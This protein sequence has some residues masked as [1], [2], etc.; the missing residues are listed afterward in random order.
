MLAR[1]LVFSAAAL[2]LP[3]A[4]CSGSS[5]P[6]TDEPVDDPV[7]TPAGSDVNDV[8]FDVPPQDD[9][10][11]NF[12][13][14][15]LTVPAGDERQ[16]CVFMKSPS[17]DLY[18]Q[19]VE[20]LQGDGGHHAILLTTALDEPDGTVVDCTN[21][22]DM[23]DFTLTLLPLELPEGYAQFLPA[24]TSMVLQS[25]YVN[26]TAKPLLARDVVRLHTV[27]QADVGTPVAPFATHNYEVDMPALGTHELT[28]DCE[29]DR[30]ADLITVGGHMHEEGTAF[31]LE[32]GTSADGAFET[33]YEVP[34]WTAEYRDSPPIDAFASNPI[35]VATGDILRT[36]CAWNNTR[37][38]AL[39]W[40]AEMCSA[41]GLLAGSFEPYQCDLGAR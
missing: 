2:L 11:M 34:E 33:V 26:S 20:Q 8:R 4:G 21:A 39:S 3:V 7:D 14:S 28:F 27:E 12:V 38:E 32:H 5:D 25:H 9:T 36:T 6:Q 23:A 30:E 19:R 22:E 41:F 10:V 35:P 1:L 15:D 29:M 31:K 18:I 17:E 24:N 40:P 16:W 13:T 37:D